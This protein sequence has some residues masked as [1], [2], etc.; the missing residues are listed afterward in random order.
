MPIFVDMIF[1]SQPAPRDPGTPDKFIL[2]HIFVK[3][4]TDSLVCVYG[5]IWTD[6]TVYMST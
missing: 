5:W 4:I 1:I 6:G 3:G 2:W